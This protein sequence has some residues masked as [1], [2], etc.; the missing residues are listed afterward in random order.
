M[1]ALHF[2]R[3]ARLAATLGLSLASPAAS[4]SVRPRFTEGMTHGFLVLKTEDEKVIADGHFLQTTGNRTVTTRVA[5]EF[6]DGS[7]HDEAA[8]FT[9][10][11]VLRLQSYHLLQRGPSF[12]RPVEGW[13]T[14]RGARYEVKY[15]RL[16]KDGQEPREE[17]R[18][19]PDDIASGMVLILLQEIPDATRQLRLN[20]VGFAPKP[21]VFEM[22][23]ER[24]SDSTFK[25]PL[26]SIPAAHYV[27]KPKLGALKELAASLAGK[28]PDPIHVWLHRGDAPTFVRM[29]GALYAGGP[30]WILERV[31]PRLATP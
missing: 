3:H 9:Q 28:D 1:P 11:G 17:L 27:V 29:E 22:D 26:R 2:F 6:A 19:L 10:K 8:T 5:L 7:V 18:E 16:D 4:D 14:R 23:I 20:Y 13:V 24:M 15:S 31:G 12:E 25:L 21:Q 30:A